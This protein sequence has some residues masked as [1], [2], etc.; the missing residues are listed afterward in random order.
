VIKKAARFTFCDTLTG[1]TV[2]SLSVAG[3]SISAGRATSTDPRGKRPASNER[4]PFFNCG[5]RALAGGLDRIRL[6]RNTCQGS[7][8]TG[9]ATSLKLYF[10]RT[11]FRAK[12]VFQLVGRHVVTDREK[13]SARSFDTNH[14]YGCRLNGGNYRGFRRGQPSALAA[15]LGTWRNL[16]RRENCAATTGPLTLDVRRRCPTSSRRCEAAGWAPERDYRI[17]ATMAQSDPHVTTRFLS[18]FRPPPQQAAGRNSSG[19]GAALEGRGRRRACKRPAGT[20][21]SRHEPPAVAPP[22]QGAQIVEHHAEV[23]ADGPRYRA[24][25]SPFRRP[26]ARRQVGPDP[27]RGH[28]VPKPVDGALQ[29]SPADRSHLAGANQSRETPRQFV[30]GQAARE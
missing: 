28:F 1:R 5:G 25:R 8:L 16:G 10:A 14:I 23:R 21:A 2:D 27:R 15:A 9:S 19:S 13:S 17:A 4:I 30:V 3:H 22:R 6:D 20:R 24:V 11:I 12:L 26:S 18:H 7:S 29:T